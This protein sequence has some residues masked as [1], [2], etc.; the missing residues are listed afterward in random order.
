LWLA[1]AAAALAAAAAAVVVGAVAVAVAAAA[2]LWQTQADLGASGAEVGQ[3]ACAP[4]ERRS[5]PSAQ[6]SRACAGRARRLSL[7]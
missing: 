7:C 4:I 1:A 5:G 6:A 3:A 2:A